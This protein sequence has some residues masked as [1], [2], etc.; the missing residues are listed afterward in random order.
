MKMSEITEIPQTQQY[1]VTYKDGSTDTLWGVDTKSG[2]APTAECENG[3]VD[4][5]L[6]PASSGYD[7]CDHCYGKII[8][9]GQKGVN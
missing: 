4:Q 8:A 3:H 6:H 2:F 1:K 9:F 5:P 7:H